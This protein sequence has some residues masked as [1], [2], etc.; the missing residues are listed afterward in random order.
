[1][2]SKSSDRAVRNL[3]ALQKTAST[4]RVL[5]L[6]AIEATYGRDPEYAAQPFFKS[7]VLNTTVVLKHRLRADERYLFDD[8]RHTATKIIVP[9]ERSDLRLGGRSVFVGQRSWIDLITEV[10]AGASEAMRDVALMEALDEL[11]SLDPFLLREHLKRRGFD[12]ARCYFAI[13]PSDLTLMQNYVSGEISKL[14]DLAYENGGGETM[15]TK[16][17]ELL[18]SS[19]NDARL[20]P[21]RV[22]LRLEGES[23][24]EGVFCWRGF[25]YYKWVLST[26][27]PKLEEVMAEAPK[28][29]VTG[30]RDAELLGYL[31]EARVRLQQR[32]D[33]QRREVLQTLKVYDDAFRGLTINQQ[34]LGFRDFLLKAPSMFL[35]LGDKIGVISHIAS[36][37]RYRFPKGRPLILDL[38][39]A[40][41]IIQEF[42]IGLSATEPA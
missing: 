37:W 31:D 29:K 11:P 19:D 15:T 6:I 35:T 7:K 33:A 39:E 36:F 17:V 30:P 16:L 41:D 1:M 9:F 18:L 27:W 28:L 5:N 24:R 40:V 13:S 8:G 32:I 25:L 2:S 3:G 22:T 38:N 4:S 26:L 12:I 14:I 34:P 10:G 23:Y 42:E 20:E 21:L